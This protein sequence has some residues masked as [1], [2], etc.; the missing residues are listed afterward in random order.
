MSRK[1]VFF[2]ILTLAIGLAGTSL[3][4]ARVQQ[5]YILQR[6]TITSASGG[7][8][9]GSGYNLNAIVGQPAIGESSGTGYK[10]T[11]GYPQAT[12]ETGGAPT[13][14]IAKSVTPTGMVNYGDF[15]TY[16]LSISATP[17]IEVG[18]YDPL[19]STNFVRFV[20]PLA[21]IAYTDRVITGTIM[22][23]PTNQIT[24]SF[25]VQVGVPGTVGIY[26][27]VSNAACVYRAAQTISMCEWS[28]TVTNQAY[29]PYT[30]FLP[31][32]MR[33]Q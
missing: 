23:T 31:L 22:I 29:R 1:T 6:S 33:N 11:G 25:V 27:D 12:P 2:I 3:A 28:N 8:L 5:A 24:V 7:Q 21:G 15:L 32:V 17:G 18:I 19:T 13:M 26:V 14:T 9:Q 16:T 30:I 10:V 20:E 4:Y